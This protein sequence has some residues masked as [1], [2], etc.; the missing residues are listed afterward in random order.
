MALLAI[1]DRE[2]EKEKRQEETGMTSGFHN[3]PK[4]VSWRRQ[5]LARQRGLHGGHGAR[6]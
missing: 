6:Q 1:R 5:V 3:D 2:A 4:R